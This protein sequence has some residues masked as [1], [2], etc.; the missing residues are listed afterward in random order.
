MFCE[1]PNDI[2]TLNKLCDLYPHAE[3][4]MLDL[5][6]WCYLYKK[7]DYERLIEKYKG[8]NDRTDMVEMSEIITSVFKPIKDEDKETYEA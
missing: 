4:Y 1:D 3:P 6:L 2:A 8:Y 5:F 7:S